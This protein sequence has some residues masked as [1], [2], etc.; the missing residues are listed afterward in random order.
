MLRATRGILLLLGMIFTHLFAS[1]EI[2]SIGIPV[3]QVNASVA[4]GAI[5]I[6][7]TAPPYLTI[8]C[9]YNVVSISEND[10]GVESGFFAESITSES[11][12]SIH[13]FVY[14]R[15][16]PGGVHYVVHET[17]SFEEK[18]R[19]SRDSFFNRAMQGRYFPDCVLNL[20]Q[21]PE[22]V[23]FTRKTPKYGNCSF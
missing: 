2:D 1:S 3:L 14:V 20:I 15:N 6:G 7:I 10:T 17:Q 19:L 5:L 9:G 16:T 11:L 18:V 13:F 4:D 22:I 21:E 8:D 12:T 23:C